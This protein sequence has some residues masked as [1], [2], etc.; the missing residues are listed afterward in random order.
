ML[1]VVLLIG[2][3]GAE[4][5]DGQVDVNS[6]SATELDKLEGIGPVKA[7]AIIDERSFDSVDDLIDVYGIGEKTLE[8]IKSQ[9]LACV[10]DEESDE[11]GDVSKEPEPIEYFNEKE[12]NKKIVK[13]TSIVGRVIELSVPDTKDIKSEEN[14]ENSGKNAY[15]VYG[16]VGFCV[17][18]GFLF[19]LRK[20]KYKNEFR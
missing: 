2:Q 17:L 20:R 6:A 3:V 7:Q 5:S 16:F 1:F 19:I 18:L 9:G 11:E 4:C 14:I 12:D 8:K 13:N 10:D 15:A